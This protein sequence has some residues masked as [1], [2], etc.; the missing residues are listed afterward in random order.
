[1]ILKHR[2]VLSAIICIRIHLRQFKIV[3]KFTWT[4]TNVRVLD[5]IYLRSFCFCCSAGFGPACGT[6]E[7]ITNRKLVLALRSFVKP[8]LVVA[9]A[10]LGF[11]SLWLFKLYLLLAALPLLWLAVAVFIAFFALVTL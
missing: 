11:F 1:M 9:A 7:K 6:F 10:I 2:F 8:R 3:L 5:H 4:K